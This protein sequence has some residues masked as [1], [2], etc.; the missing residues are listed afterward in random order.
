MTKYK[1]THKI[2]INKCF[3]LPEDQNIYTKEGDKN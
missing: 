3:A 1:Y 2:N